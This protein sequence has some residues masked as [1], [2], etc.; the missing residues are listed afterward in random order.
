MTRELVVELAADD[1]AHA[2]GPALGRAFVD[3]VAQPVDRGE[4][5]GHD[6]ARVAV[7]DL[8]QAKRA[9][10]SDLQRALDGLWVR[11]VPS[12]EGVRAQQVALGVG[13]QRAAGLVERAAAAN[14]GEDVGEA[15]ARGVVVQDV[16]AGDHRAAKRRRQGH[17]AGVARPVGRGQGA[18]PQHLQRGPEGVAQRGGGGGGPPVGQQGGEAAGGGAQPLHRHPRAALGRGGAGVGDQAAQVGPARQ[19]LGDQDHGRQIVHRDRGAAQHRQA[20]RDPRDVAL[21]QAVGGVAIGDRQRGQPV[22]DGGV[23]QLLGV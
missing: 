3:Q 9:P 19:G 17:G 11:P 20:R 6:L 23:D 22:A 1:L 15:G 12:G 10:L 13:R 14:A 8:R 18:G 16:L 5:L 7:L 21:G 4:A 2:V